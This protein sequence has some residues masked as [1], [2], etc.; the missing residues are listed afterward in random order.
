M[1]GSLRGELMPD[2]VGGALATLQTQGSSLQQA[3]E[4]E[5]VDLQDFVDQ[6]SEVEEDFSEA[7]LQM[8]RA[9]GA[10]RG[11]KRFKIET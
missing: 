3:F 1:S 11:V 7:E 5:L 9:K 6:L 2:E 10:M 4:I 8:F